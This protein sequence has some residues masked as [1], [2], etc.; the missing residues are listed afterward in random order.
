M[1]TPASSKPKQPDNIAYISDYTR[2]VDGSDDAS[3]AYI[4][5]TVEALRATFDSGKTRSLEWRTEQLGQLMRMF[6]K[7]GQEIAEATHKDVGKPV[8]DAYMAEVAGARGHVAELRKNLRKYTKDQRVPT[9]AAAQ[10]G[11]SFIHTEPLGV[12]LVIAPWNFPVELATTPMAGAIAAGNCVLLKPSEVAPETSKL[13][14]RLIP[15]YMDQDSVRVVEGA[16]DETTELLAQ[17]FD[18]IFYTGNGVVG[19]IVMQAAAKHLTPVTLELGGKSPC[20]VDRDCDLEVTARRIVWGKYFNC[21]QVCVAADYLLVHRDIHDALLEQIKKTIVEF[22]GDDPQKSVDYGRIVNGRHHQRVMRLLESGGTVAHG[23]Q[24]DE[25]DRY[26]APTVLTGVP[27]DAAVMQEEIFGPLMPILKVDSIDDAIAFVNARPKPLALYYFGKSA[28]N[29][30]A[31]ID[32]T[33]SGGVAINQ[34]LFQLLGPHL[35]FGGVGESGIG[36]YHGKHSVD[37]FSHKKAVVNRPTFIDPKFA[38][39]PTTEAK[40][41]WMKRL[42]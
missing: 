18:H 5:E 39:P 23:G 22:Y 27:A 41:K 29:R 14:A 12:V 28:A 17:R 7:H 35:P 24:A 4:G 33:S 11:K 6:S 37:T 30:D 1:A 8:M 25:S 15:Q 2:E 9:V 42:L 34:I 36:A 10:P 13:L 3:L 38:Y 19:R 20:I 16:V 40:A 32:R 26:I 31:V 21:G